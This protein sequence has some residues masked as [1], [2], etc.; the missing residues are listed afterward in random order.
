MKTTMHIKVDKDVKDRSQRLATRMG[1]SVS[2]IVNASL[3]NFVRTEVFSVSAGEEMTPFMEQWLA[4]I[5]KDKSTGRNISG[6]F[7]S[8][9]DLKRHLSRQTR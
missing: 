4:E 1:L 8:I 2:A 5:E 6:P 9:A 3:R 7:H